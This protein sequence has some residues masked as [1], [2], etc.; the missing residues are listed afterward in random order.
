[1][2]FLATCL[3]GFV[4]KFEIVDEIKKNLGHWLPYMLGSA[5]FDPTEIKYA[6]QKKLDIISYVSQQRVNI[7]RG[8]ALD[9]FA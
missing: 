9:D 6:T 7:Q 4:A 1:M 8:E 5:M 3:T 2:S